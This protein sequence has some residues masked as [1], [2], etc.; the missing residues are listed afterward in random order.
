[1]LSPDHFELPMCR[2]LIREVRHT[3]INRFGLA[4][5]TGLQVERYST[6][7]SK[8]LFWI[9]GRLL[10][11]P[12]AQKWD[13]TVLYDI[14]NTGK[15]YSYGVRASITNI[16]ISF[17]MDNG[18]SVA[19][20]DYLSMI[21]LNPAKKG[22]ESRFLSLYTVH[23][24]M[25]KRYPRLLK[26]LYGPFY[27]DRQKEHLPSEPRV[28][29]TPLFSYDGSRLTTRLCMELVRQGYQLMGEELDPEGAEALDALSEIISDSRL[30]VGMMMNRGDM[31]YLNN[32]ECFHYRSEFEDHDDPRLKRHM[33]RLWHREKGRPF[34]NG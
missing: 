12:V 3:L 4:Q 18:F 29:I 7:E 24:E 34:Y 28:S 17:H 8:A 15:Q 1:M 20:P 26:R 30:S 31:Q 13:G 21:C 6:E 25:L 14:A 32:L 2:E 22:G 10:A 11:H 27:Q 5:I 23:N 33:F 19:P 9:L 16:Q